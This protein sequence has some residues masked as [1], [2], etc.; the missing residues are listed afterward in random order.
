VEIK[1]NLMLRIS[2]PSRQGKLKHAKEEAVKQAVN[3]AA[4]QAYRK[5]QNTSNISVLRSVKARETAS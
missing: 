2:L 1:L 4:N 5:T 3:P